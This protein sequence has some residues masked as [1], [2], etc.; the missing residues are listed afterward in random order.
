VSPGVIAQ[1][2]PLFIDRRDIF[3]AREKKSKMVSIAPSLSC[4]PLADL[5][6]STTGVLSLLV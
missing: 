2:Q 1:L 3:E 5:Y 4:D 6:C